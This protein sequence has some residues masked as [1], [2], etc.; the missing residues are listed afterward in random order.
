MLLRNPKAQKS[1]SDKKDYNVNMFSKKAN[2][3][4]GKNV[5]GLSIH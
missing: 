1:S 4:N 2:N 5:D 3:E